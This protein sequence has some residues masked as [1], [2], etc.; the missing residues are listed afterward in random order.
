MS[1]MDLNNLLRRRPFMPFR[2]HVSDQAQYDI[3]SH[4]WMM[5]G[6]TTAMIGARR[7]PNSPI[8]DEPVIIALRHITRVEPLEPAN[9]SP[10]PAAS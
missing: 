2:I 7:D 5:V 4:E 8:Y 3:T 9:T 10:P 1:P 6:M